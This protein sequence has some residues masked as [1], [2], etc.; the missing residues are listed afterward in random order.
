[1]NIINVD[2]MRDLGAT[3]IARRNDEGQLIAILSI[4]EL[5]T[6]DIESLYM[7]HYRQGR[8][9]ERLYQNGELMQSFDPD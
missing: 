6:I 2:V 9:D 4:D 3:C 8:E 1:M 7:D 5:P